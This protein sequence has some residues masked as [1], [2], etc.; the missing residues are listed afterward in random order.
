MK[1]R[2]LFAVEKLEDRI[3]KIEFIGN[4][5][6]NEYLD[7]WL[8]LRKVVNKPYSKILI[9]DKM[10][11]EISSEGICL[12]IEMLSEYK[13]YEKQKIAVV[14]AQSNAYNT[15][16]FDVVA[17]N[18]GLNIKHFADEEEAANWLL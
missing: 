16:F 12:L 4:R 3:A 8:G 17:K 11:G 7:G 5:D 6:I 1:E 2:E 14:L 18:W 13:F 9:V 10:P 15:R